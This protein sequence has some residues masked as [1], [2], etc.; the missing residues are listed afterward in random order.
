M[1]RRGDGKRGARM[2]RL[3]TRLRPVAYEFT[4]A[5]LA[6]F[7]AI[8]WF[9]HPHS[10]TIATLPV[11]LPTMWMVAFLAGGVLSI[12]G[13]FTDWLRTELAGQ[14]LLAYG[15]SFFAIVFLAAGQQVSMGVIYVCLA[16]SAVARAWTLRQALRAQYKAERISENK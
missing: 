3:G 8:A 12:A 14:V 5:L 15:I 2:W 6:I 10:S 16:L 9:I 11:W 1:S 7:T 4:V 13:V